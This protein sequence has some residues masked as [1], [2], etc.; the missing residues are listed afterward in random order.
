M[1]TNL[2]V[3]NVKNLNACSI[4]KYYDN[5]GTFVDKVIKWMFMAKTWQ[6]KVLLCTDAIFTSVL[7]IDLQHVLQL[8]H[9]PRDLLKGEIS[10]YSY[11][12]Y[13]ELIHQ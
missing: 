4:D 1:K 13:D 8:F 3:F 10:L 2:F 5:S 7:V 12:W 6:I 11:W 9:A